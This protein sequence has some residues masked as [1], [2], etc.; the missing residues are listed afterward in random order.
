MPQKNKVISEGFWPHQ[1]HGISQWG[2]SFFSCRKIHFKN[3]SRFFMQHPDSQ[4][5]LL[6]I[7]LPGVGGS[8]SQFF[9]LNKYLIENCPIDLLYLQPKWGQTL[10]EQSIELRQ[11]IEATL[12]IYQKYIAIGHSR[13]GL[14]G[15]ALFNQSF[16]SQH[17]RALITL[18]TPWQRPDLDNKS[19]RTF[20]Y[21]NKR[22]RYLAAFLRWSPAA[23]DEIFSGHAA[24]RY[25]IYC[26]TS[27]Y[28]PI[29]GAELYQKTQCVET[30]SVS[31]SHMSMP[32][33]QKVFETCE[34]IIATFL[35]V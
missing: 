31:A 35:I 21:K 10:Q 13:G 2:R 28:D 15:H 22:Y 7:V 27:R 25:P 5:R 30:I 26:V 24:S 9:L 16:F 32:F 8:F 19:L 4:K 34:K 33:E 1:L 29:V 14:L 18:A 17:T 3:R 6:V 11:W 12:P 20:L 23:L